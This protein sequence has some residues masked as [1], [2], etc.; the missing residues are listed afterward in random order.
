MKCLPDRVNIHKYKPGVTL[1]VQLEKISLCTMRKNVYLSCRDA[2][3]AFVVEL[4]PWDAVRPERGSPPSCCTVASVQAPSCKEGS[5]PQA[6]GA[7][8]VAGQ[9]VVLAAAH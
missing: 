4:V 2:Y 8:L 6:E 3:L 1:L 5:A 9:Q 7:Q